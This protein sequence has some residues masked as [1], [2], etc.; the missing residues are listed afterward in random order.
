MQDFWLPFLLTMLAGLSTGVGGI[1]TLLQSKRSARFLSL[2]MGFSAGVMIYVSMIELFPEA[3]N[4][5]NLAFGDKKGS[6]YTVLAFF[7]GML[8][9]AIIDKL[10]PTKQNPHEMG[11]S[12]DTSKELDPDSLHRTFLLSAI[13]IAIHNFP[14]GVA[15]FVSASQSVQ[16]ALPTVVAIA[17]HN[18]PEGITIAVPVYC[19][20]GSRTKTIGASFLA[21]LSEPLGAI[22][23]YLFLHPYLSDGL[24][25]IINAMVAGIMVFISFDELLPGA[26]KFGEHHIAIYG[27]L[28][29][30]LFMALSLW[31]FV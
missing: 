18:I 29:G 15:T 14:E 31:L 3:N 30:M 16:V 9:I 24:F 25:G 8:L 4:F 2:C 23:A 1:I 7:A 20:T 11:L 12:C 17:L 5:L 13:A 10:I 26:E 21:G 22:I 19:A 6:L 28:G 27:L